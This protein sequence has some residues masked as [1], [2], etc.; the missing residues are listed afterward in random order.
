[1]DTSPANLRD[2][3][4]Y[5]VAVYVDSCENLSSGKSAP[6]FSKCEMS[7][8]APSQE[9]KSP[10]SRKDSIKWIPSSKYEAFTTKPRG[11]TENPVFQ[12]GH[13]FLSKNPGFDSIA[14]QIVDHRSGLLLGSTNVRVSYIQGLP[15]QQFSRQ[16]FTLSNSLNLEATVVLSAKLYGIAA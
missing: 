4:S 9:S 12:E 16:E 7:L 15:G 13:F 10:I 3:G 11:P 6:P 2:V 5:V 14:V 1:M 8:G